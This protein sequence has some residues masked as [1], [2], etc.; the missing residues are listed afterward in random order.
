ME[1]AISCQIRGGMDERSQRDLEKN[2]K[3]IIHRHR[4]QY[5]DSQRDM[6]VGRGGRRA[7]GRNGDGKTLCSG[8]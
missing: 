2:H 3:Y 4:Q 5:G 6:Q 8:P 1:Q 7:K